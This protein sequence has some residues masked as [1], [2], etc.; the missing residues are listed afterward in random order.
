MLTTVAI[1]LFV[2]CKTTHQPET[3]SPKL[4]APESAWYI[5][6][7][8]RPND[9]LLEKITLNLKWEEGLSGA[10]GSLA[11]KHFSQTNLDPWE[12]KWAAYRSGYPYPVVAVA[13]ETTNVD[14]TPDFIN[15]L[16]SDQDLGLARARNGASDTWVALIGQPLFDLE[17]VPRNME[18]GKITFKP[19]TPQPDVTFELVSPTGEYSN[20]ILG[21]GV[22]SILNEV[23]E[24]WVQFTNSKGSFGFPV[25][26]GVPAVA[27]GPDFN[28]RDSDL[29]TTIWQD[30][31]SIRNLLGLPL[32][33][34]DPILSAAAKSQIQGPRS[35]LPSNM[36]R[37]SLW[38][39]PDNDPNSCVKAW[40]TSAKERSALINP[41]CRLAGM[42]AG[43]VNNETMVVLELGH[44]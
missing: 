16:V 6:N 26:V 30:L 19:K 22:E 21:N 24:W 34:E 10:A 20:F 18:R 42:D 9:W 23:G 14:K 13:I 8:G 11:M 40:F 31:D 44:E 27:T 25:Y 29:L 38:C 28:T 32:F 2:A 36:C 35:I 33:T 4:V 5:T 3:I 15:E 7:Y 1:L 37:A 12:I 43:I 17:P 41:E 39:A